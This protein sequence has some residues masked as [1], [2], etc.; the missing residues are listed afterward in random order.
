MN[1]GDEEAI[2]KDHERDFEVLLA[3]EFDLRR[4]GYIVLADALEERLW[5]FETSALTH[6]RDTGGIDGAARVVRVVERY[7]L[8]SK[9]MTGNPFVS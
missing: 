3:A 2:F 9:L 6:L 1:L 8:Q 7:R 5:L 4:D